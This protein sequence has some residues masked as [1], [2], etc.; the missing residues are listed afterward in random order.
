MKKSNRAILVSILS[1]ALLMIV[2]NLLL[3]DQLKKGHITTLQEL[4]ARQRASYKAGPIRHLVLSGTIWVNILPSADDRIEIPKEERILKAGEVGMFGL[5]GTSSGGTSPVSRQ[6]GDTLYVFGTNS[7]P[8]H[9]P[10]ADWFYRQ[11][12]GQ[13]YVYTSTLESIQLKNGQILIKGTAQPN[14]TKPLKLEA[15][16][17]TIWLAEADGKHLSA[18]FFDSISLHLVNSVLLLN[19]PAAIAALEARLDSASELTDQHAVLNRPQINTSIDSRVSFT[20]ENL[21]ATR[22]VIHQ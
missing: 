10:Y 7:V 1:V 5:S 11:S 6:G 3:Y 20:G 16:G 4:Q 19:K 13:I 14:T 9:R 12:L 15:S 17:S 22:I 21:K 18:E 8:L 2:A